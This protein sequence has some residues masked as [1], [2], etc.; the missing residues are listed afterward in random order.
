M[1]LVVPADV[2]DEF[3]TPSGGDGEALPTVIRHPVAPSP[4]SARSAL[5]LAR[6][7]VAFLF[8]GVQHGM[9][10]SR[11]ELEPVPGQLLDR[12]L[13]VDLALGGMMED[14]QAYEAGREVVVMHGR[15]ATN[16]RLR[17]QP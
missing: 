2:T 10:R 3:T 12:P 11:A 1:D 14:V 9:K 7:E 4:A 16:S 5:V 13:S 6:H 8:H 17:E 15:V